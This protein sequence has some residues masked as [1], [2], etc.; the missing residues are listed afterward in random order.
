MATQQN[1]THSKHQRIVF[2]TSDATLEGIIEQCKSINFVQWG[3]ISIKIP[4]YAL[5]TKSKNTHR[6]QFINGL[7]EMYDGKVPAKVIKSE[8][9]TD[10][11]SG[12]PV[13][14]LGYTDYTLLKSEVKHQFEN[15]LKTGFCRRFVLSF[16]EQNKLEYAEFN[17]EEERNLYKQLKEEGN[18]LYKIFK[19]TRH[20]ANY[21]VLPETI[22]VYN[23]YNKALLELYNN[24]SNELIQLE[25]LSRPFKALK[26]SCLYA[27][28]N[29][30][31]E[32]V[33]KPSD[34]SQAVLTVEE[35][36][37]D[38]RKYLNF[39]PGV[40][41]KY[42]QIYEFFKQNIEKN[43]TKTDLIKIF[44]SQFGFKREHLRK[45]FEDVFAIIQEIAVNDKHI[46]VQDSEKCK[47]GC[48]YSLHKQS[49]EP[50]SSDTQELSTIVNNV[51]DNQQNPNPF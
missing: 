12:I 5:Y 16:H 51:P 23:Q 37:I 42:E 9:A 3:R 21:K 31:C 48:Y 27:C 17:D 47:N 36:A 34:F 20:K 30:S 40:A 26:L 29:H 35:L 25:L 19:N 15:H 38:F 2:E 28:L 41:D 39:K 32:E 49:E 45:T 13:N 14:V 33:I 11:M 8:Q 46:L 7:F 50:L 6:E 18:K 1:T 10:N 24:E 44:C 43:Y 4:E 22:D